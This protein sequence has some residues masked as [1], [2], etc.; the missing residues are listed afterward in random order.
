MLI[1]RGA[2]VGQVS[3][4]ALNR[5]LGDLQIDE[6][7]VE[8]ILEALENRGIQIVDEPEEVAAPAIAPPSKAGR[9]VMPATPVTPKRSKH[10][11][12]DDALASLESMFA[13]AEGIDAAK[14]EAETTEEDLDSPAV[15]DAYKHYMTQITRVPLLS[16]AEEMRLANQ[17]KYGTPAEQVAAK[18]KLVEAN[19]RL[20]VHIARRYAHRASLPLLDI[21]QE[22]NVGLIKAVERF[23]PERGHRLS[24]YATW[25]IRQSINKAISDQLRSIRLP[26]HLSDAIAKIHR[27]QRELT[28]DLGRQP[29]REEIATAVGM[30]VSQ[31][32]EALAVAHP[33]SLDAPVGEEDDLEFQD[34]LSDPAATD[35]PLDMASRAALR[36]EIERVLQGLSERERVIVMKRFGVGDY[37]ATG[38][39]S[40]EEIADEMKLSRERVRQLEVRALRKLRRPSRSAALGDFL[41]GGDE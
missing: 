27:A 25:W 1:E 19:L 22:G 5:V 39:R 41:G 26:Q 21:V 17:T 36:E 34:I 8:I 18:Q 3:Y 7:Q 2:A 33:L 13:A 15:E 11:D 35:V 4:E 23:K 29:L 40:L 37:A 32:E 16:E 24:T 31:V 9:E 30:K 14:A 12:L 28:Q 10:A 38:P 20:V 6:G